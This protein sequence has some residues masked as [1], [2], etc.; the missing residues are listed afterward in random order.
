MEDCKAALGASYAAL[1]DFS[2]DCL[3]L[4]DTDFPPAPDELEGFPPVKPDP[5]NRRA[6]SILQTATVGQVQPVAR[7]LVHS[8]WMN[9]PT[10]SGKLDNNP[11]AAGNQVWP[12][13]GSLYASLFVRGAGTLGGRCVR[14][15][16][17]TG[18]TT[19]ACTS[20]L[21]GVGLK[22]A[23]GTLTTSPKAA[24]GMLCAVGNPATPTAGVALTLAKVRP[25]A[26]P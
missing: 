4:A 9:G 15:S 18:L 26:P 21:S 5:V 22:F 14:W 8:L 7:D 10:Y 25:R 19:G 2:R 11:S 13:W 3:V 23:F 17:T 16:T 20:Y 24:L 12:N 1:H 6:S